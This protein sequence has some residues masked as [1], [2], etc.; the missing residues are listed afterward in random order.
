MYTVNDIPLSVG[1]RVIYNN[2]LDYGMAI[3][4]RGEVIDMNS[5]YV[6][7][8]VEVLC[9]D[10]NISTCVARNVKWACRTEVHTRQPDNKGAKVPE[11]YIKG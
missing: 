3:N 2:M 4:V 6:T 7:I 5:F 10:K 11:S 8:K 9:N 1:D